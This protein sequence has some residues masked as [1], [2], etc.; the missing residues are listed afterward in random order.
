MHL[1]VSEKYDDIDRY[2][3]DFPTFS[4]AQSRVQ[5]QIT[6][7]RRKWANYQDN[8]LAGKAIKLKQIYV[9]IHLSLSSRKQKKGSFPPFC[10]PCYCTVF[11]NY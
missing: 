8:K 3:D 1:M 5:S 4:F 7:L 10:L 2:K 6:I 9:I 11:T